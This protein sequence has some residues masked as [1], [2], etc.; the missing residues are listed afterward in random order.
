MGGEP[1]EGLVDV[2]R[3]AG[4]SKPVWYFS[5]TTRICQSSVSNRL[6]V[7]ES[8]KPLTFDSVHSSPPSSS[9]P[10]GARTDVADAVLGAVLVE[11]PLVAQHVEA[12]RSDDHRL[13]MPAD[14]HRDM[15]AEVVDDDLGALGE[16]VL[17]ERNEAGDRGAG[18]RLV[19]RRVV[20]DRL[21]DLEVRV[22][23]DVVLQDVVDELLLDGLAHRVVVERLVLAG[24]GVAPA[25]QLERASLRRGGDGGS[26]SG[27]VSPLP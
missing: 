16:V 18:A 22:V 6:G 27:F 1:G 23:G 5:A 13:R 17:V 3:V 26:G 2:H 21:V 15:G 24:V 8:G 7:S 4:W 11:R 12:R 20:S 9:L 14:L 25:E 10:E 19:E